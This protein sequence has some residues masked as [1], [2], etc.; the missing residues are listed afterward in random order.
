MSPPS[1]G[2]S[3]IQNIDED[4]TTSYLGLS[5]SGDL[6]SNVSAGFSWSEPFVGRRLRCRCRPADLRGRYRLPLR[7][8]PDRRG[9]CAARVDRRAASRRVGD[10]S[11]TSLGLYAG[12]DA[13]A[14]AMTGFIGQT[15]TDPD[16]PDD[17][18]I[19][20]FGLSA[21]FQP[22][23]AA[24]VGGMLIRPNSISAPGDTSLSGFG[25]AGG[26][27]VS[28][29]WT[30][31]AGAGRYNLDAFDLDAT[32]VGIGAGYKT[33]LLPRSGLRRNL[34]HEPVVDGADDLDVDSFQP[35]HLLPLRQDRAQIP[36]G[37]VAGT[38]LTDNH[39]SAGQGLRLSF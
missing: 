35:R 21:R 5:M 15:T 25:V 22:T 16:L 9:L 11:A 33:P 1:F 10:F 6:G 24:V 36:N 23:E 37:T 30:V 34:A 26:V 4:L 31:F 2:Q 19:T 18:D 12:Y 20:D 38:I 7:S 29:N 13:G 32:T 27:A 39:S 14:M 3:D 8:G 28:G 17:A